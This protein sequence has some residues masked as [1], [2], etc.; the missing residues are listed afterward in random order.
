MCATKRGFS[1]FF[2]LEARFCSL[3]K[4]IGPLER[5]C[6]SAFELF[7]KH[8]AFNNYYLTLWHEV[9]PVTRHVWNI[10]VISSKH[11]SC[12]GH[13]S[14]K[15]TT[16]KALLCFLDV[17]NL[18]I[19]LLNTIT[20]TNDTPTCPSTL[21]RCYAKNP[22]REPTSLMSNSVPIRSP[23]SSSVITVFPCVCLCFY[24]FF[25]I[26]T[27][28]VLKTLCIFSWFDAAQHCPYSFVAVVLHFA[29]YP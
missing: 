6:L 22:L 17:Q 4:Y 15:I 28:T 27:L 26:H 9:F 5:S 16:I 3:K 7:R 1:L 14:V 21:D 19:Y 8:L 29:P 20:I 24:I 10:S 13:F 11:V 23:S 12:V 18:D 2:S 25:T